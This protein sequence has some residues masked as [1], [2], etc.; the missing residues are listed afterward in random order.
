M[1][2]KDYIERANTGSPDRSG[3]APK[4]NAFPFAPLRG[5]FAV[6]M[7]LCGLR[8]RARKAAVGVDPLSTSPQG[9]RSEPHLAL[10]PQGDLR[11]ATLPI[12]FENGEGESAAAPSLRSGQAQ[13]PTLCFGGASRSQSVRRANALP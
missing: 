7:A 12:F 11:R 8:P 4:A 3:E 5:R 10:P 1:R 2:T 13:P 6:G 9:G